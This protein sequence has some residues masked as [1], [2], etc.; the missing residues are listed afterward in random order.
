MNYL[1][2]LVSFSLLVSPKKSPTVAEI[3]HPYPNLSSF[4][5]NRWH[6]DGG[7]QLLVVVMVQ[8]ILGLVRELIRRRS[9]L[10]D[11][12]TLCTVYTIAA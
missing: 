11:G 3:T 7:R 10:Q 9:T 1:K 8:W 12:N 5:F 2:E 6:W 4:L